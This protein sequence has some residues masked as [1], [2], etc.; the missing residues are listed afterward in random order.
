[1]DI[2]YVPSQAMGD[3]LAE[4]GIAKDKILLYPRGVDMDLFKPMP[5]ENT[6]KITLLYVGR[7]SKEKNLD[8]LAN[9]FYELCKER[10]DIKLQIV[11]DGPY[12][13]EMESILKSANVDF[14]GY[15][16]RDELAQ[17][18]SDADLFVFP[19]TTD[20]FGNVI[21]EAQACGTPVIVTNSGGPMENMIPDKTGI[22]V[23]GNDEKALYKGIK[24]LLNKEKLESMRQETIKYMENRSFD[25]AFLKTWKIY[26]EGKSLCSQLT[27]SPG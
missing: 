27:S 7:I 12:K 24:S 16:S 8:T 6:E 13:E 4:K 18:Y 25:E 23:N 26:E 2:V 11:G 9:A 1:M 15:K 20:T 19:S 10:D 3:E 17:I 14:L 21:L 5:R 22:I